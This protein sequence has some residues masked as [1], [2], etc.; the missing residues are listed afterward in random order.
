MSAFRVELVCTTDD[1][2]DDLEHHRAHA[3]SGSPI[4]MLPTWRPDRAL[5]ADQPTTWNAWLDRLSELTGIEIREWDQLLAALR[6]RHG[7][8]HELGCRLSDHGLE[9]PYAA[10]YTDSQVR[11]IF[12]NAR[13]GVSP[14]DEDLDKLRSALMHEFGL[15]DHERGWTKQLH[16]GALRNNNSRLLRRLGADAGVDSIADGAIARPLSRYL[17]R[18]DSLDRLPKVILY[19]LNPRD[20]E[21]MATMIGNFQDGSIPGKLQYGS[22]WWFLDQWDGMTKQIE[23]LSQLGLLSR[24]VGMLTDSRSFVSYVRHEYFRRLLC[25][26][27]GRDMADGRIPRDFRLVGGMVE[28]ISY[29]NAKGYFG[30]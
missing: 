7:Y 22:A 29:R 12:R 26:L 15:M 30:F 24:F 25:D 5:G 13:A 18:L 9:V 8:F 6:Q 23:A 21:L 28:D 1:P 17:D 4:R 16:I 2:V 20:N 10:D 27:L 11:S 19:N 14:G 3:A